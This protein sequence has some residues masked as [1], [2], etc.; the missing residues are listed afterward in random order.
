MHQTFMLP[1]IDQE[2]AY[3]VWNSPASSIVDVVGVLLPEG[4]G[5]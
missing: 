4:D 1:D 5:I 3:F 2:Y